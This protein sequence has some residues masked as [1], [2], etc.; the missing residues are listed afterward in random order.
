MQLLARH[1]ADDLIAFGSAGSVRARQLISDAAAV[2]AS[3]PPS[4]EGRDVLIVSDDRYHFAVAL[5]AAWSRGHAVALP[6]NA[7]DAVIREM[8]GSARVSTLLHDREEDIGLDIRRVLAANEAEFR[9]PQPIDPLRKLAVVYTSGSTGEA[10]GHAKTAGQLLGEAQMLAEHFGVGA[11]TRVAA[12]VPSHHIYGLL[13]SVLVPLMGGASFLRET[14]LLAEAVGASLRAHQATVLVSVPAHLRALRQLDALPELSRTFSS[15]APLMPDVAKELRERFA[16]VITEVLGSTETGGM[17]TRSSDG[18]GRWSPLPGV[19]VQAE[20]DG[21]LIVDSPFLAPDVQRPHRSE[22]RI[23]IGDDGRFV[24]AGRMDDVIKVA[25]KRVALGDIEQKLRDIDGVEDAAVAPAVVGGPRG[26]EPV[27]LV[28]APGL[29]PK[30]IRARLQSHLD[31][32]VVPRR[33]KLVDRIERTDRGKLPAK[34]VL[35]QYEAA[36]GAVFDVELEG[37]ETS[38]DGDTQVRVRGLWPPR[39]LY[40]FRGHFSA[41]PLVPGVVQL[42]VASDEA[43]EAWSDLMQLSAVRRLKFKRPIRPGEKV[44]LELRRKAGKTRVEFKYLA[45]EGLAS[46]GVL[47]FSPR[48]GA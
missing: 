12:T 39:D 2:A 42:N 17:A 22:D 30:M 32:V 13:F 7:Q 45:D 6:P 36:P 1:E 33:I 8:A 14:S 44:K 10:R 46:S 23:E 47:D 26:T 4:E 21:R 43:R 40:W 41:Y 35:A 18:D 9:R 11:G 5:L 34:M 31:P 25:G 20:A 19:S 16:L 3:L 24:H 38:Q 15:G 28:V 37:I 48:E 27:A 29:Y